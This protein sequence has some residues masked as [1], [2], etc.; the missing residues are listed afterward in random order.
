[1]TLKI[2][3]GQVLEVDLEHLDSVLV[4]GEHYYVLEDQ[5]SPDSRLR[6]QPALLPHLDLGVGELK[7]GRNLVGILDQ[8]LPAFDFGRISGRYTTIESTHQNAL[9]EGEGATCKGMVPCQVDKTVASHI[10]Q[11]DVV[12]LKTE[13]K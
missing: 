2:S 11:L 3:L 5:G 7:A 6:L 9:A 4:H 8:F 10:N 12:V 13:N 1:M